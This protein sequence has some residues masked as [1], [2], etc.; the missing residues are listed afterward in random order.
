[1]FRGGVDHQLDDKGR[2]TIPAKFRSSLSPVCFL[3]RGWHGCLFIFPWDKWREIEQRLEAVR[4]TDMQA[5][6]VQRF[7]SSGTEVQ[8]DAQ[9][10]LFLPPQLREYAGIQKDVVIR[11]TANRIEVWSKANWDH[12]DRTE[13]SL[14]K[15]VEKAAALG[16]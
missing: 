2:I 8:L 10:R 15:I 9:G 3:T 12:Y 5:I 7:F 6:A 16:I 13:L 14:E 1:M 11:G 4:I